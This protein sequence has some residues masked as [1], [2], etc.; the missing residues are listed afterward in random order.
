MVSKG[1]A[2]GACAGALLLAGCGGGSHHSSLPTSGRPAA[3]VTTTVPAPSSSAPTAAGVVAYTVPG[4]TNATTHVAVV[5]DGTRMTLPA[6]LLGTGNSYPVGWADTTGARLLIAQSAPNSDQPDYVLA[7]VNAGTV[8][9]GPLPASG[10][11]SVA[12]DDPG[13]IGGLDANRV[14]RYDNQLQEVTSAVITGL[15]APAANIGAQPPEVI[16]V[17]KAGLVVAL[18]G[19][20]GTGS[21]EAAYG[22][23]ERIATIDW[24]GHV[25]VLPKLPYFNVAI[26]QSVISPDGSRIAVVIGARAGED[27]NEFVPQ[28]VDL[29]TGAV[30]TAARPANLAKATELYVHDLH[31]VTNTS[32]AFA[33]ENTGGNGD[34]AIPVAGNIPEVPP[35][36]YS[37]T[38]GSAPVAGAASTRFTATLPGGQMLSLGWSAAADAAGGPYP[39][40]LGGAALSSALD[41]YGP[42]LIPSP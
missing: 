37:W 10:G 29:T 9:G 40:T 6:A 38:P 11:M 12:A 15:P 2:G 32:L 19:S 23:P 33:W 21:D 5:R 27:D 3:T 14:F 20:D 1:L 26:S 34:W 4:A 18:A 39:L 16:G 31:W 35:T 13:T 41:A 17:R 8:L 25:H 30:Q 24:T 22:G 36:L 42:P 28:V 7:D